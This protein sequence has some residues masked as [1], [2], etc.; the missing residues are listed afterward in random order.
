VSDAAGRVAEGLDARIPSRP[1]VYLHAGQVVVSREPSAVTTIL[2][3]CVAVCL[4]DP[5]LGAGGMNHF[6]LPHWAGNGD[7]SPRFGNVAVQG[8]VQQ[9]LRLGSRTA[10]LQAK[11]FGGAC[12]LGAF[13]A[14]AEH[15][16]TKNVQVA[17]AVL[18]AEGI[19][20]VAEDAGGD[21]GR[22]VIF[23]TDDGTVWI[24]RL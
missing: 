14:R 12:V 19:P 15:L 8:L 16:G 1:L 23:H 9:M 7:S 17:R 20:I 2:G 18:A 24:R 3:S 21:R 5:L 22:K 10:N 11:V 13:R 4:W 6:L